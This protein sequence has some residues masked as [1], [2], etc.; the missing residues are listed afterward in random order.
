M[1]Q[2][3]PLKLAKKIIT[4]A[5]PTERKLGESQILTSLLRTLKLPHQSI[6]YL[7]YPPEHLLRII[8]LLSA[9]LIIMWILWEARR[10]CLS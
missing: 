5:A 3:V 1:Y 10:L 7:F 4:L 9:S 2:T 8:C 6:P